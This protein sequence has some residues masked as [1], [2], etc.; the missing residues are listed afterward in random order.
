MFSDKGGSGDW[1][2][3]GIKEKR[4]HAL[5]IVYIRFSRALTIDQ[6]NEKYRLRC[7]LINFMMIVRCSMYNA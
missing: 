6:M 7:L 3:S 5:L 1:G 4:E 2:A